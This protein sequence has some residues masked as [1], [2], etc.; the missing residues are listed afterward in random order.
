MINNQ[1]KK[2]RNKV[3]GNRINEW[4]ILQFKQKK[5]YCVLIDFSEFGHFNNLKIP[6]D[7]L[8]GKLEKL[9]N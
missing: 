1:K 3:Q 8:I 2:K 4:L 7:Y 9:N 5:K 6:D